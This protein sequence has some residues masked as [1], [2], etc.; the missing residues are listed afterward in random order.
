MIFSEMHR[1]AETFLAAVMERNYSRARQIIGEDALLTYEGKPYR[2]AAIAEWMANFIPGR[3]LLLQLAALATYGGHGWGQVMVAVLPQADGTHGASF[4]LD[5]SFVFDERCMGAISF[6]PAVDMRFP[7]VI[8]AFIRALNDADLAGMLAT[9]ADDA[10]VND[11]LCEHW[12]IGAI[13]AWIRQDIL[14]DQLAM[15]VVKMVMHYG[16]VIVTAHVDG[17][18]DKRGLPDPL[19]LSFYF[20]EANEKIVQLIILRNNVNL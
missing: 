11:Q 10:V 3:S 4:R 12:G 19:V 7:A 16:N 5:Y 6:G 18:Y 1:F 14:A 13:E 8:L 17:M 20:S 9:F 15:A 2:G